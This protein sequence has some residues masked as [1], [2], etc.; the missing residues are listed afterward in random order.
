MALI[1]NFVSFVLVAF[2]MLL[3][4]LAVNIDSFF[5]YENVSLNVHAGDIFF[6]IFGQL[7]HDIAAMLYLKADQYYHGGT[8]H[9][10]GHEHTLQ[11]EMQEEHKEHGHDENEHATVI[12]PQ[13]DLLWQIN[14]EIADHPVIHLQGKGAEEVTPWFKMATLIDPNFVPAYVVGGFWIGEYLH[15]PDQAL[16]FLKKGLFHNPESWQLYEQVGDIYFTV[17]KDYLKAIAYFKRAYLLMNMDLVT[18]SQKQKVLLFLAAS[19]EVVKDYKQSL[20]YYEKIQLISPEDSL[21]LKKILK[22][23]QITGVITN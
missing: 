19:L 1:K 20:Y 16:D 3:V 17:K 18:D 2:I 22:L 9:A 11:G 8:A 23:K 10:L 5:Y 12:K 21:I 7:R 6:K 15:K 13:A 14:H 4:L